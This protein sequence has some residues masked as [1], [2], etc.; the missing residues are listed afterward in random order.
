MGTLSFQ[1]DQPNFEDEIKNN[2]KK[3]T[4]TETKVLKNLCMFNSKGD[5]LKC[6]NI[7]LNFQGVILINIRV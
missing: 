5:N 1:P 6:L 3:R 4:G 2:N 7:Y